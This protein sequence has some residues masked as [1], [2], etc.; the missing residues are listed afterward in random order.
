MESALWP[1]SQASGSALRPS[2]AALARTIL[3]RALPTLSVPFLLANRPD[4]GAE[5]HQGQTNQKAIH[6]AKIYRVQIS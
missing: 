6:Q 5:M 1:T 3:H 4:L 2:G